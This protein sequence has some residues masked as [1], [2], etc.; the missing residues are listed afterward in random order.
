MPKKESGAQGRKRRAR[1]EAFL[2][3]SR[4]FMKK[5]LKVVAMQKENRPIYEGKA[6]LPVGL[7]IIIEL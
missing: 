7:Q 2:N 3:E 4:K 6:N 1:F 5:F